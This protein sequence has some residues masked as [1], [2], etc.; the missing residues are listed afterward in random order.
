MANEKEVDRNLYQSIGL[1]CREFHKKLL[2]PRPMRGLKHCL[3]FS[4]FLCFA[5]DAYWRER[6]GVG[7]GNKSYDV[8]GKKA[9][10]SINFQYFL[11]YAL[12]YK[13][14]SKL[15]HVSNVYYNCLSQHTTEP[16]AVFVNVSGVQKSIPRNRFR[17]AENRFLGYL[18][19]LQI[20]VPIILPWWGPP[21][22][23]TF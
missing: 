19:G 13:S 5:G 21:P 10:S 4:V 20:R 6:G 12:V 14:V 16:W 2:R 17:Q 18:K 8:D 15:P 11:G 3:S 22:P 1:T 9:W 23:H 7:G